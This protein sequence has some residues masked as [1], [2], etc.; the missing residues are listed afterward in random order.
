MG[1]IRREK[2]IDA[3]LIEVGRLSQALKDQSE[4]LLQQAEQLRAILDRLTSLESVIMAAPRKPGRPPKV[5][6]NGD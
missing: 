6:R 4:T 2:A 3:A 5:A 1:S